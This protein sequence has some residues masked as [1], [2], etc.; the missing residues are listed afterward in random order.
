VPADGPPAAINPAP[1]TVLVA[2]ADASVR[3]LVTSALSSHGY[4]VLQAESVP[5]ALRIAAE[6]TERIDL[7]LADAHLPG[8]NGIELA[9][10]IVRRRGSLHV[11]IM[12][13]YAAETMSVAGLAQP[14]TFLPKPFSPH[15]LWQKTREVLTR[16]DADGLKN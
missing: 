4:R 6:E 13:G 16:S 8:M 9:N 1:A 11:V 5:E 12:S 10:E 15:D 7:L 14:I 2:E 3:A